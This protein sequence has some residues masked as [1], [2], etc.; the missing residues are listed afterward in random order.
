MAKFLDEAKIYLRS[1]DGG[2]GS[3][4]FRR[5]KYIPRGGP[6]GGNGG[7]GGHILFTTNHNLNTLIDFRYKQHFKAE[8]GQHG[9]GRNRS[10]SRGEDMVISVPIGTEIIDDSTGNVLQDMNKPDQTWQ[11]LKGGRGGRGNA[12]FATSTNQAPRRADDGEPGQEAWVRLRLKL[13][14]DVGLLG[15]PNAGK[16]TFLST[17]SNARPEMADYAFTTTEPQLGMVRRHGKDMVMADL[18]GLI[19]GAAEGK[20]M[21][22][23]FLKHLS[24]CAVVLHL[25]DG[26]APGPEEAYKTIRKELEDYDKSYGSKLTDLPQVVALTK[27]DVMLDDE[28]TEAT[29]AIKKASGE[30][31][32]LISSVANEGI[33]IVLDQLLSYVEQ[34]R[35]SAASQ[36]NENADEAEAS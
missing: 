24:R 26:T 18:P 16:S 33:E 8:R 21:G 9:M 30:T 3:I 34:A 2:A 28:K 13:L 4:S 29:K 1:G 35:E 22:H 6:D 25:I 31:P 23:R 17:V 5:E 15:L 32:M 12:M 14:A 10:G 19:E 27:A 7:R 20:G 11:F 36:T